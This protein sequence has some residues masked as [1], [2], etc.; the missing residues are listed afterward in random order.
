MPAAIHMSTDLGI[1]IS[2]A[3]T[4]MVFSFL[5]RDNPFYKFAEHVFVGVSAAYWMVIG[6]WTTLWPQLVLKLAPAAAEITTPGAPLP[7]RDLTAL[8]PLLLGLL[9]L[10]RLIP[11][12][13]WLGRWPTAFVVGTT[14]GY[15][16]VRYIRSDFIYQIRATVAHGLAPVVDGRWLWQE[17]LA[18]TLILGGT[19]CGLI[20]FDHS[21]RRGGRRDRVARLGLVVILVTFGA[22]FGSAVMA[23]VALLVGR[24]QFLLGDWLGLY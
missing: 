21:R 13:A 19:I 17:T 1:W 20:Y 15:G 10:S 18:A 11:R 23:R 14:V 6:F 16:M 12:I 5:Y 22:A 2:A 7:E 8:A 24:F 3:L 9:M 4:L